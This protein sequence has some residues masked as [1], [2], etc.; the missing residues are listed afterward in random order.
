VLLEGCQVVSF[1]WTY[2]YLNDTAVAHARRSRDELLG[3]RMQDAYPG[4]EVSPMFAMLQ[5]T[6]T[7]R[8]PGWHEDAFT[9]PDGATR[10]FDLRCLPV[11]EGVLILSRDVTDQ[12]LAEAALRADGAKYHELFDR[13]QTAMIRLTSDGT[14]LLDHNR[15]FVGLIGEE[16]VRRA[17]EGEPLP[18]SEPARFEAF[19][20]D[21]RIRETLDDAELDIIAADGSRRSCLVSAAILPDD[22]GIEVSLRDLGDRF[23]QERQRLNLF[24]A[25][26]QAA[27]S[28]VVT[29]ATWHIT[30]VNPAFE[31]ITGYS[32]VEVLGQNPRVLKSGIQDTAFYRDLW[33]TLERDGLWRGRMVNRRKDGQT[34]TQESTISRVVDDVGNRVGFVAVNRDVSNELALEAQLAHAQRMET[35]GRLT[36]GIAHDFNN[37]LSVILGSSEFLLE[38]MDADDARRA[39]LQEIRAAGERAAALTRQLL[40]FGRRQAVDPKVVD[41]GQVVQRIEPM[42]RRLLPPDILLNVSCRSEGCLVKA[43][44]SQLDQL[45]MN[46]VVNARDAMPKGGRLNVQVSNADLD[47]TSFG[48]KASVR[49]GRYV[50]LIVSDTGVGMDEATKARAFEPFFTTKGLGEGTG[51]GLAMVYGIVNQSGGHIWLYSEPGAGTAFKIYLPCIESPEATTAAVAAPGDDV[52]KGELLLVVEDEA[53]VLAVTRRVLLDAGYRV[54][55]ATSVPE[56]RKT[57]E[58]FADEVALVL[59][60][61]V[62]PE[63]GGLA[64]MDELRKRRPTLPIVLMSGY[65]YD[66]ILQRGRQ[67]SDFILL[68][69]PFSGAELRQRVREALAPGSSRVQDPPI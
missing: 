7:E 30:Y 63:G 38:G 41:L 59:S 23:R 26:D 8:T 25:I 24:A 39:D 40:A 50:R 11:S 14:R 15:K 10:W 46:L 57:F 22:R 21:L 67:P 61:V 48:D 58:R 1:D 16:G 6:M 19:L 51:L 54:L 12:R 37:L 52:G 65:A 32:S 68:G 43:D 36:G 45:L 3:R 20:V 33:T 55:S 31:R 9:Y 66:A 42:I 49:P 44:G 29:D 56:A 35:I 13:A 53:A 18:W 64:L 62:M 5:R 17:R 2:R 4:I 28:V 69:K 47:L 27:E 60:D 34:Y